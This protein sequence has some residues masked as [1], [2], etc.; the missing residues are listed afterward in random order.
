MTLLICL[1]FAALCLPGS[2]ATQPRGRPR[3]WWNWR[4]PP[5][6]PASAW[7][8]GWALFIA[9]TCYHALLPWRQP[10]TAPPFPGPAAASVRATLAAPAPSFRCMTDWPL[11]HL[12]GPVCPTGGCRGCP[13]GGLEHAWLHGNQTTAASPWHPS[14]VP[15]IL[16]YLLQE[17]HL[18]CDVPPLDTP[19]SYRVLSHPSP[20]SS[21]HEGQ[22]LLL[23]PAAEVLWHDTTPS[24]LAV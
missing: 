12:C 24:T 3:H 6:T 23:H 15:P 16:A 1:L 8:A 11:P 9:R 4:H 20:S 2:G 21:S 13:A 5:R 19:P 7:L 17:T 10:S 22:L 14:S 18:P